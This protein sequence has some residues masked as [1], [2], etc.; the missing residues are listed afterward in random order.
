MSD[1]TFGSI[2]QSLDARMIVVTAAAGA[3]RAGCL[4]GFHAQSSID[5]QR[6]TVWLSK[7][8]HTYRVALRSTH[9]GVH[10]LTADD[11]SL[12]TR[13]GTLSGDDIDKF[14]GL[15]V[16][17]ADGGVP[18]LAESPHWMLLRRTALLDEGGDHV[19][20]AGQAVAARTDG[21]FQPL[22]L[23]HVSH[24]TAG[25][26]TDERPAPPTERA[27]HDPAGDV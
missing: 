4:V 10:F 20:V 15:G 27:D 6:Y 18:L 3:E 26:S 13:F 14:A 2:M 19:C 5:P 16:R 11:V 12:A 22:R 9:V 17:V 24:L 25:H 1:D 21:A 8:N 23:S 7:A